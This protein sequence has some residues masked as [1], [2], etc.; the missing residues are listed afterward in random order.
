MIIKLKGINY[1]ITIDTSDES[2]QYITIDNSMYKGDTP[3]LKDEQSDDS[4]TPIEYILKEE[5]SDD[6][7]TPIEYILNEEQS[8]EK[9]KEKGDEKKEDHI[10]IHKSKYR[11]F[12]DY[13]DINV[14][15]N[16]SR[17]GFSNVQCPIPIQIYPNHIR[18]EKNPNNIWKNIKSLRIVEKCSENAEQYKTINISQ[19]KCRNQSSGLQRM[20]EIMNQ[21]ENK[22]VQEIINI[23]SEKD[24]KEDVKEDAKED[25]DIV[26]VVEENERLGP[27]FD[28]KKRNYKYYVKEDVKE[29]DDI[30]EENEEENGWLTPIFDINKNKSGRNYN[31]FR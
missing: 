19:E 30:V 11:L 12:N 4:N 6:S 25:D 7:N 1:D 5:Q 3:I 9:K 13:N 2:L 10:K 14:D 16:L 31:I 17:P 8:D 21:E 29:N 26:E 20:K 27:I 22:E 24:V 23:I 18:D 28:S 15:S